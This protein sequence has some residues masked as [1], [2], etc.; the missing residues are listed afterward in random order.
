MATFKIKVT[1]RLG[2]YESRTYEVE[3]EQEFI[4]YGKATEQFIKDVGHRPRGPVE[5]VS[6]Y[7]ARFWN[8]AVK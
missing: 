1:D 6:S 2:K 4:A 8:A 5:R 7:Y 3:A